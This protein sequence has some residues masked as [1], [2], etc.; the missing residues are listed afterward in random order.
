MQMN[1]KHLVAA[2]AVFAAAGSVFAQEFVVP[3]A[4]FVSTRTRAEVKAEIAQARADGTFDVKDYE[5]PI[6]A[7]S[8]A[9]KN[10]TEVKAEI[11]QARADGILVVSDAA[12][13]VLPKTA[14]TKT[15]AEVRGELRQ[16]Q[17]AHPYGAESIYAGA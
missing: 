6:V 17:Q 14:G 8:G 3:D 2:F 16:Y 13:P 9:A 5:Y 11:A 12:Y 7:R 15:R 10:R 4:N 1:A